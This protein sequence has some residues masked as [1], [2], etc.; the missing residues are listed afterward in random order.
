M[1]K[2]SMQK[3]SQIRLF[4][5]PQDVIQ[6][7][8]EMAG[9][10]HDI[11]LAGLG[12][13]ATVEEQGFDES[14]AAGRIARH[15]GTD[16]TELRLTADAL[17]E[18]VPRLPGIY[19]EP[20]C[21]SS[22]IPT[23]LV[24]ELARKHVAVA[25]SGDGGDELFG[26]YTRYAWA[27]HVW[28]VARAIPAVFQAPMGHA[29]RRIPAR[30]VNHAYARVQH[31]VP[32][33]WRVSLP[34]EKLHKF[35]ALLTAGHPD[36]LYHRLMSLWPDPTALVRGATEPPGA[37][38][39]ERYRMLLGNFTERMMLF[40]LL[41]YLPDDILVKVDRASMAVSL[42][43]RAPLLDH[44]VVEWSWRLPLHMKTRKGQAKW[45]LRQLACRHIPGALLDQPKMG[46]GVPIEQW[47]RG[48]LRP[49]AED[50][51]DEGR[52][53]REGLLEVG[54]IRAAWR[55]HLDGASSHHYQLWAVLMF[56]AWR[57]AWQPS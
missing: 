57:D 35:S 11:W 40:D 43:A 56:Q 47:L 6:R 17:L 31:V 14:V 25:V 22:Q 54:P 53:G 16:H 29:L 5:L 44:R 52:L 3:G 18:T 34:G 37:I 10:G 50:L 45:L 49:W 33:A 4:D 46:F 23:L 19:D 38:G 30:S 55:R 7:G 51:L 9:R 12:A 24:Y 26:G 32:R 8:R 15:L 1:D 21:D 39:D 41:T 2:Q 28:N 42:E 48:P 20:F 27:A 13:V 36:G